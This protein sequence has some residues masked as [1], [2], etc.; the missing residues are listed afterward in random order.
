M[1]VDDALGKLCAG[2][3]A[4]T[5]YPVNGVTAIL[6]AF[7]SIIFASLAGELYSR[8]LAAPG[9]WNRGHAG[10]SLTII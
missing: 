5:R 2:G 7:D 8:R 9:G 4:Y 6:K 3:P 10:S 1:L